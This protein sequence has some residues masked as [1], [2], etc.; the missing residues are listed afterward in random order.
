M[1]PIAR[2]GLTKLSL[3]TMG[4]LVLLDQQPCRRVYSALLDTRAKMEWLLNALL[5][6]IRGLAK[7]H[8]RCA[9]FLAIGKILLVSLF[10]VYVCSTGAHLSGFFRAASW[11]LLRPPIAPAEPQQGV[12]DRLLLLH[13]VLVPPDIHVVQVVWWLLVRPDR[14]RSLGPLRALSV[15]WGLTLRSQAQ[16]L[17]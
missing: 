15:L 13:A 17:V 8:A 16:L 3:V 5:V 7:A 4:I 9:R 10:K 12:L 1:D 11:V 2:P 6:F 14:R